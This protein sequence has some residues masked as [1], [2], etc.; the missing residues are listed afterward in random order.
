MIPMLLDISQHTAHPVPVLS[1]ENIHYRVAKWMYSRTM[2][3]H[4]VREKLNPLVFVYGVW[5]AYKFACLHIHRVF[6][7]QFVYLDQGVLQNGATVSCSQR[8]PFVERAIAALWITGSE[9]LERL[10]QE[11]ASVRSFLEGIRTRNAP[12][13]RRN[14]DTE[15]DHRAWLEELTQWLDDPQTTMTSRLRFLIN[16]RLLISDYCAAAFAIGFKV[17]ECMWN[18]RSLH[19]S[20]NAKDALLWTLVVLSRLTASNAPPL[21]YVRTVCTALLMWTTWQDVAPGR[22]FKDEPCEA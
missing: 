5:H 19:S 10:D 3:P 8:L 13:H 17:R 11:I 2:V 1:D 22:L 7:S 6:F 12:S 16:M 9:M 21:R 15:A 20:S 4:A 18:G 14:G